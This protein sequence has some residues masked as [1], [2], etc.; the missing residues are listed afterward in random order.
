MFVPQESGIQSGNLPS[1]S[2]LFCISYTLHHRHLPCASMILRDPRMRHAT[3][4]TWK[5]SLCLV[6]A[7]ILEASKA[8]RPRRANIKMPWQQ[9]P[10]SDAGTLIVQPTTRSIPG[11]ERVFLHVAIT[12]GGKVKQREETSCCRYQVH[13][14]KSG[15]I[16]S[17]SHII[18]S[19]TRGWHERVSWPAWQPGSNSRPP[20][21]PKLK[22]DLPYKT[23]A[24]KVAWSMIQ[25]LSWWSMVKRLWPRNEMKVLT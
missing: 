18:F 1:A 7:S 21:S 3:S 20:K 14:I 9:P 4:T 10:R 17:C 16:P 15:I 25:S 11:V 6:F 8:S 23:A 5:D 2:L 12:S 22:K 13:H 24:K 19:R